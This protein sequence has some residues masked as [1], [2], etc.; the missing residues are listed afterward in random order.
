[1]RSCWD[2]WAGLRM[3]QGVVSFFAIVD[4]FPERRDSMSMAE[5]DSSKVEKIMFARCLFR[6]VIWTART[7]A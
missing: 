4:R 6:L 7:A 1:M 2:T 3:I 5:S